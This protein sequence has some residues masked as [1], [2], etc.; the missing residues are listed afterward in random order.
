MKIT[1]RRIYNREFEVKP[2]TLI[3]AIRL[4]KDNSGMSPLSWDDLTDALFAIQ[5]I[6]RVMGIEP[7]LLKLHAIICLV[8]EYHIQF[9]WGLEFFPPTSPYRVPL[10]ATFAINT[11]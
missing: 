3:A 6:L 1:P 9:I 4:P 2:L 7:K 10:V 5:T 11:S 8:K